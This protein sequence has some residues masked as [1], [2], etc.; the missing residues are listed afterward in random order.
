MDALRARALAF[1]EAHHVLTLA[2]AGDD[3]PWAAAVFYA[4]RGFD[5]WFLS[6]PR[7]RHAQH[8][9]VRPRAAGAVQDDT[10]DWRAVRGIQ[11]EGPVK[12]L[13]GA[14]EAE[15]RALY[16]AR[17]PV[18]APGGAPPEIAAALERVA[19]YRLAPERLYLV[20]NAAGFGKREEI[21]LR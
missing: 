21:P 17:F 20:D 9:A 8:L 1:L 18:A 10:G 19:W 4:S 13:R 5:L 3:G 15:A 7:S 6:S 12:L 2:T 11:L 14:E 16:G